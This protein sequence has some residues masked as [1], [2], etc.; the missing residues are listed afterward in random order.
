MPK[1]LPQS[2]AFAVLVSASIA[3]AAPPA[4][5]DL[6]FDGSAADL[7]RDEIRASVDRELGRASLDH[8]AP[9]VPVLRVEVSP[10]GDLVLSYAM[11][12]EAPMRRV[13]RRP[14]RAHDVAEIIGLAAATLVRNR[15]ETI[16]EATPAEAAPEKSSPPVPSPAL[17]TKTKDPNRGSQAP[18][19]ESAP[20]RNF[21]GA[22][23]GAD[24]V[25]VPATDAACAQ[26]DPAVNQMS[27][28]CYDTGGGH[29]VT[30]GGARQGAISRGYLTGSSRLL[31]SYDRAFTEHV[32]AG[33]RLGVVFDPS[34]VSHFPLHA[35][36]RSAYWFGTPE[37]SVF[38]PGLFGGLGL[39]RMTGHTT[40]DVVDP[41]R[42]RLTLDAYASIAEFF[43][44]GG[45]GLIYQPARAFELEAAL[46]VM[47]FLPEGAAVTPQL[48]VRF[49]L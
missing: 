42:G 20:A 9:G 36:L 10:G 32:R 34:P 19:P 48:A 15:H 22:V 33:A 27:F 2:L 28:S 29:V 43:V 14:E 16:P 5:V 11:P 8:A 30:T 40:V 23:V 47:V 45:A 46:Q 31:V 12:D 35:E 6:E 18:N 38:R 3:E 24:F 17:H 25:I 49:G 37:A 13:L 1:R 21:F 7:P 41:Q 39:T 44:S 26:Q 4:E